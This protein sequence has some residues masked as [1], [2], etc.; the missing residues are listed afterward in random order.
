MV[1]I[2]SFRKRNI[3][4]VG[5]SCHIHYFLCQLPRYPYSSSQTF[6][7]T[8]LSIST[9]R[10]CE[11]NTD[12]WT[13]KSTRCVCSAAEQLS[14]STPLC[15]GG[16]TSDRPSERS[17]KG[18]MV[19]RGICTI[20]TDPQCST[21]DGALFRFMAPCTYILAKTCV[22]IRGLPVFSV[23]VVNTQDA[24]NASEATVERINVEVN[25]VRLSLLKRETKR[26]MVSPFRLFSGL[27]EVG[28]KIQENISKQQH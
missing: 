7:Y 23:E 19:G 25:N 9:G 15:P 10:Q 12:L 13:D 2:D 24:I 26:V 20:H 14:C 3:Q 17:A 1:S 18:V 5:Y 28:S 11:P 8:P 4:Q 6:T 21:F 22:P 16:Q 27:L